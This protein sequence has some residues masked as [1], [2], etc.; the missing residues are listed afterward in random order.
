MLYQVELQMLREG[1]VIDDLIERLD[2]ARY[3]FRVNTFC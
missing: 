2:S 1:E 3:V